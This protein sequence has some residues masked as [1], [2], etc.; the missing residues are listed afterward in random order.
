LRRRSEHGEK[1][2]THPHNGH[3]GRVS[4]GATAKHGEKTD[5]ELD[6]RHSTLTVAPERRTPNAERRTPNAERRTPNAERRTP[7]AAR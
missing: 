3:G 2:P 7:N 5:P 1:R 4:H 6:T